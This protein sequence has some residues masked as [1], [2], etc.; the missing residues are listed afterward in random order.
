MAND[1]TRDDKE[2]ATPP[3][4]TKSSSDHTPAVQTSPA[5]PPSVE[6]RIRVV[7]AVLIIAVTLL[8]V[9]AYG[10]TTSHLYINDKTAAL[11][12]DKDTRDATIAQMSTFASTASAL[13]GI[14]A[15]F[16]GTAL[17]AYFGISAASSSVRT[18]STAVQ[19]S[20]GQAAQLAGANATL[21]QSNAT[22]QNTADSQQQAIDTVHK[23]LGA[24]A[25]TG[26]PADSVTLKNLQTILGPQA[27]Q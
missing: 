17:G 3:P 6:I 19:S 22:L 12:Q 18:L 5:V 20:A 9:I 27:S 15:T 23:A 1:N 11:L 16:L 26:Q 2:P 10:M 21:Q 8:A 14:L 7:S 24:Q 13:F 25:A 4:G